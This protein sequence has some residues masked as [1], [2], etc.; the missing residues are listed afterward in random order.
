M[1]KFTVVLWIIM[2]VTVLFVACGTEN[3]TESLL[4][5][6]SYVT[7]MPVQSPTPA[8]TPQTT[9]S[10]TYSHTPEPTP[11]PTPEPIPF[12]FPCIESCSVTKQFLSQFPIIFFNNNNNEPTFLRVLDGGQDSWGWFGGWENTY[13]I[14][15]FGNVVSSDVYLIYSKY[16]L[17]GNYGY[18][19]SHVFGF[20]VFGMP[21]SQEPLIVRMRYS[22]DGTGVGM[23]SMLYIKQNGEFRQLG[24]MIYYGSPGM[25]EFHPLINEAGDVVIFIIADGSWFYALN[26]EGEFETIVGGIFNS[27]GNFEIVGGSVDW[28][29][30]RE[31]IFDDETEEYITDWELVVIIRDIET[32]STT[33]LTIYEFYEILATGQMRNF[34][35][36]FP[37]GNFVQLTRMY[38]LEQH[39]GEAVPQMMRETIPPIRIEP[40]PWQIPA[41]PDSIEDTRTIE[42]IVQLVNDAG[43]EVYNQRNRRLDIGLNNRGTAFYTNNSL[44]VAIYE[45]ENIESAE[46]TFNNH[47]WMAHNWITNGRFLIETT[48]DTIREFFINPEAFIAAL[49]HLLPDTPYGVIAVRAGTSL[50]LALTEDGTLWSWGGGLGGQE[51][52]GRQSWEFGNPVGDGTVYARLSPVLIL[53]DVTSI[54]AGIISECGTLWSI[55]ATPIPVLQNVIY[56]RVAPMLCPSHGAGTWRKYVITSDSRLWA[57]GDNSIMARPSGVLGDGST[58]DIHGSIWNGE[59]R[60]SEYPVLIMENVARVIPSYTGGYVITHD[61]VLWRWGVPSGT[62]LT[63][64]DV[65]GGMQNASMPWYYWQTI[66]VDE[67]YFSPMRIMDNVADIFIYYHATTLVLDMNGVLW[68]LGEERTRVMDDVKTAAITYSNSFVVT[69][70]GTLWAWGNNQLPTHWSWTPLL[71]DGTTIDRDTPVHIMDNVAY[72]TIAY[73]TVFVITQDN[74]LWGW[75]SNSI[76]QLGQGT[77]C[78]YWWANWMREEFPYAYLSPVRIMEN[79]TSISASYDHHHGSLSRIVVFSVTTD[80]ELWG[81]GGGG[82]A[83]GVLIPAFVG[84]GT[85]NHH[86]SPVRIF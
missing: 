69:N 64:Y 44:F 49:P 46:F 53:S 48:C 51:W 75:G 56:A 30:Q 35:S 74:T 80:G 58:E 85:H 23:S 84:D 76:G 26:S 7:T 67:K 42:Y 21:D 36:S 78:T 17:W 83:V 70:D 4:T 25:L 9:P 2:F 43:F 6:N 77:G 29:W 11:Y 62:T 59:Y 1:R 54:D 81:W 38:D 41:Q 3:E 31:T 57:W 66:Y 82:I 12:Y 47:P 73:D 33:N 10:P 28:R 72:I 13:F 63:R 55:G 20:D 52:D 22:V 27:E 40:Q 19:D 61:N 60:F 14:D 65:P 18:W 16:Q 45:M 24:S 5:S 34:F 68:S 32:E 37:Y 8:P 39:L 86:L 15:S 79:V 50:T 71:G